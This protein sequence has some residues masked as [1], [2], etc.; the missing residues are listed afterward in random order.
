MSGGSDPLVPVLVA[1]VLI[2]LGFGALGLIQT[3]V[4]KSD[5]PTRAQQGRMGA[6]GSG[7]MIAAGVVLYFMVKS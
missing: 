1:L 7:F 3:F 5:P 2:G 4:R 6:A